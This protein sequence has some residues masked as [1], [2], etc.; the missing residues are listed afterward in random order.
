MKRER[1]RLA[2]GAEP[3]AA[4]GELVPVELRPK[5]PDTVEFTCQAGMLR[6][7]LVADPAS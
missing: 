2:P 6:G 1:E 4:V 7:R 5:E 3:D